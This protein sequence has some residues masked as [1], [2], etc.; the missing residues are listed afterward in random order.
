[1]YTENDILQGFVDLHVHAGPSLM[2]REVDAWEMARQAANAGYRAFV[3]KDHHVPTAPL[4]TI[5]QRHLGS[6]VQVFGGMP[7]NH[8]VGGLN[9]AGVEVAIAFG[10]KVV[11]LPTVSC[12]NHKV[13]HSGHGLKF[14]GITA[15]LTAQPEPM[16]CIDS[17]GR[18]IP[19]AE[20]VL[21][22]VAQHSEVI[23]ATGHGN[24]EEVDA[25]VRRAAELGV[26]RIL[27]NHPHYMVDATLQDLQAWSALGANIEFNAVLS[28]P[29]SKFYCVSI[30]EVVNLMKKLDSEYIVLSSDYGQAGNG[31]PVKGMATFVRLLLKEGLSERDLERV[32]IK[33]PAA[34]I[35]VV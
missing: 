7:T 9:P 23:L 19:A 8:S 17:N 12:L 2:A 35:G 10:A 21:E 33:N 5:V 20:Q 25:F 14:P 16:V 24:R 1:M 26:E 28:V 27:V 32:L 34:L 15:K 6:D 11:W 29:D 31:S 30:S 4:A 18:L 22:V 3:V 13:K